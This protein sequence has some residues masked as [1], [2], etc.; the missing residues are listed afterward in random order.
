MTTF[1]F[2]DCPMSSF[3]LIFTCCRNISH[4]NLLTQPIKNDLKALIPV[5]KLYSFEALVLSEMDFFLSLDAFLSTGFQESLAPVFISLLV[6]QNAAEQT[7]T[8]EFCYWV[9]LVLDF[10]M[11]ASGVSIFH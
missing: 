11:T 1:K 6:S 3:L 5:I 7:K 9:S 8:V 10:M 4:R 2:S